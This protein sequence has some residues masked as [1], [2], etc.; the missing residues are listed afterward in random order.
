MKRRRFLQTAIAAGAGATGLVYLNRERLFGPSTVVKTKTVTIATFSKAL[1]NTPYYI[2]RHFGWFQDSKALSDANIVF[3]EYNDRPSISSAFASG[4]LQV[5]FSA[6]VPSILCRA[7][8]DDI[9]IAAVSANVQQNILVQ[10]GLSI[11]ALPMLKGHSIAVLQG[12][13]SH[14]CLLKLLADAGLKESDLDL[15]YMPAAEARAAFE[16][17]RLDAWAVWA[18]FVEEQQASGKG[19]L[20]PNGNALINSVMSISKSF[21]ENQPDH[22][23]AVA[24]AI[25]KA[26][27][28]MAGNPEEGKAIAQQEL[29]LKKAV[30]DLAWPKHNWSATLDSSIIT[31][32]QQKATFLV[33]MDKTRTRRPIDVMAELIDTRFNRPSQ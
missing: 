3:K 20:L 7:Q 11:A 25:F 29:S 13:S 10:S 6:D 12:T 16:A 9:R 22:A 26:K 28:W 21:I 23:R 32:I 17:G 4:E 27:E 8:G 30:V 5:L 24:N 1:G 19:R 2:A 33:S 14:Y 15:R 18:P 31:D